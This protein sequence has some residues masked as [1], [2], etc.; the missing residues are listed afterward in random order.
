MPHPT[1][2]AAKSATPRDAGETAEFGSGS[3]KTSRLRTSLI[4]PWFR[5]QRNSAGARRGGDALRRRGT[6]PRRTRRSA[7]ITGIRSSIQASAGRTV[8]MTSTI[9]SRESSMAGAFD[10]ER[11][12]NGISAVTTGPA[13]A[14]PTSQYGL[15]LR[16]CNGKPSMKQAYA[17]STNNIAPSSNSS[18]CSNRPG[19]TARPGT[20]RQASYPVPGHSWNSTFASKSA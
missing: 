1:Q 4:S 19:R 9:C 18:P 8:Q 7:L 10:F 17:T 3:H 16:A 12:S 20:M 2:P 14:G 13:Q 6:R 11:D 5:W 15:E